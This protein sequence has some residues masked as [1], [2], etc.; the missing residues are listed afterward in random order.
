[1]RPLIG[2]SWHAV[3]IHGTNR[4]HGPPAVNRRMTRARFAAVSVAGAL[5]VAAAAPPLAASPLVALA[6]LA[7][8]ALLAERKELTDRIE[9]ISSG[10]SSST[11]GC[12][13]THVGGMM[14]LRD[15]ATEAGDGESADALPAT[16]VLPRW[17]SLLDDMPPAKRLERVH[18]RRFCSVRLTGLPLI[19]VAASWPPRD[20]SVCS[21]SARRGHDGVSARCL[22]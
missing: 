21:R 7:A 5:A 22:L 16:R 4:R 12:T 20:A 10:I 9:A 3:F 14:P 17:R 8:L 2:T 1:M 13:G 15:A 6:S 11:S 19:I 18:L